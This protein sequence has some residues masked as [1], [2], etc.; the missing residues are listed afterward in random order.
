MSTKVKSA[1]PWE[2]AEFVTD[3]KQWAGKSAT[4]KALFLFHP[5]LE[6]PSH[7][8]LA[9]SFHRVTEPHG[10]LLPHSR[11]QGEWPHIP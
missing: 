11:G 2:A 7:V 1:N 9:V 4:E 10:K 6:D 5:E 3:E 8:V